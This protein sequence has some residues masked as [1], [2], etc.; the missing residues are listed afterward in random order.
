MSTF[1]LL[2]IVTEKQYLN[3]DLLDE[4]ERYTSSFNGIPV[5]KSIRENEV[6]PLINLIKKTRSYDNFHKGRILSYLY[7]LKSRTVT[8]I[9]EQSKT[10]RLSVFNLLKSV[11]EKKHI[12]IVSNCLK[13]EDLVELDKLFNR[14]DISPEELQS[15]LCNS[16]SE[17]QF[18]SI[19]D[20]LSSELTN[21]LKSL[22]EN[23]FIYDSQYSECS[24]DSE[25]TQFNST[26]D[27]TPSQSVNPDTRYIPDIDIYMI[28]TYK[29]TPVG[30]ISPN[31]SEFIEKMSKLLKLLSYL[32][33][34]RSSEKIVFSS[35]FFLSKLTQLLIHIS[36]SKNED[37]WI[38]ISKVFLDL[39]GLSILFECSSVTKSSS[40]TNSSL[41]V[42]RDIGLIDI[43]KYDSEKGLSRKVKLTNLGL[44]ITGILS[45]GIKRTRMKIVEV[46][47]GLINEEIQDWKYYDGEFTPNTVF[48]TRVL[49]TISDMKY[50]VPSYIK[51]MKALNPIL[52]KTDEEYSDFVL[53]NL[54]Q[55]EEGVLPIDIK[56]IS[57]FHRDVDLLTTGHYIKKDKNGNY[58][59]RQSFTVSSTGRMFSSYG[60][61]GATKITKSVIHE[62]KFNYDIPNSQIRV[63]VQELEKVKVRFWD[64]FNETEKQ[65]CEDGLKH[66]IEYRDGDLKKD[67]IARNLRI[68]VDDWKKCLYTLV[69][70]GPLSSH[71]ETSIGSITSKYAFTPGFKSSK[72]YKELDKF[73]RPITIWLKYCQRYYMEYELSPEQEV[74]LRSSVNMI[75]GDSDSIKFEDYC[76]NGIV[77]LNKY[78][79]IFADPKKL[80]SFILQGIESS[81]IF[82]LSIALADVGIEIVSYEFDG[83]VTSKPIPEKYINYAREK[84]GFTTGQVLVKDFTK[85]LED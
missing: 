72:L 28:Y 17:E 33:T 45:V 26:L 64:E 42:L 9:K 66:L 62:G 60:Y 18:Y 48:L 10:K 34:Y 39:N 75:V 81:F 8:L 38:P 11:L 56:S 23:I 78:S 14:F 61:Q 15:E 65:Y 43:R 22:S 57:N 32:I 46:V 69:F 31:F 54:E 12:G 21:K 40:S 47:P 74:E 82:H 49:G 37:D 63:L 73:K 85:S 2:D 68:S 13:N 77:F 59:Q 25:L 19:T 83:I 29:S 53:D 44:A 35:S 7:T 5:S 51:K 30:K 67:D 84:S 58:Q 70:G 27:S 79:S 16:E 1:Y 52:D 55:I 4:I 80:S 41:Y 3:K 24:I 36:K 71:P 6:D 20:S 50:N 76:Y